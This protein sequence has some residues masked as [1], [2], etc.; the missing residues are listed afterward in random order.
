MSGISRRIV[1]VQLGRGLGD[2][3]SNHLP[4]P[5]ITSIRGYWWQVGPC[6][7]ERL[8]S[9]IRITSLQ[10]SHII[11]PPTSHVKGMTVEAVEELLFLL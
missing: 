1:V 10:T 2:S 11:A 6:D 4:Y 7:M 9:T 3:R 5:V 8:L